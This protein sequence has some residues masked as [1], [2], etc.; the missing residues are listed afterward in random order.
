MFNGA[1]HKDA[2]TLTQDEP[3][4][5][6]QMEVHWPY[7]SGGYRR[8]QASPG[9]ENK[10]VF[11]PKVFIEVGSVETGNIFWVEIYSNAV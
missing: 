4:A 8:V 2:I 1:R 3:P 7:G 11:A 9:S 5:E 6:D 10:I